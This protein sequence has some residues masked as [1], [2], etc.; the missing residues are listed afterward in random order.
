MQHKR[1]HRLRQQTG[2]KR[3]SS[4]TGTA[5]RGDDADSAHLLGPAHG[6]HKDGGRTGIHGAQQQADDGDGDGIAHDIGHEPHQ[7]LE[8]G[9]A[10]EDA[11]HKRLLANLL[12]RG[13]QDEPTQGDARPE[14]RGHV[15]DPAGVAAARLLQEG[16]DPA[17]DGHLGAL[18]GEDEE[19]AE[20]DNGGG[21]G[22]EH[23]VEPGD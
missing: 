13:R 15:P 11:V 7:Q 9:G 4:A 22:G 10:D 6:P 16:D 3:G 23:V 19:R 5:K 20:E 2:G 17:A 21:E 18:V 8:D 1:P 12:R 14:P